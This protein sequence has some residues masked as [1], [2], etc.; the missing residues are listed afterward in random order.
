M[1]TPLPGLQFNQCNV[2]KLL[3]SVSERYTVDSDVSSTCRWVLNVQ[4][5]LED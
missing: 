2:N 5:N 1:I 3:L 4:R